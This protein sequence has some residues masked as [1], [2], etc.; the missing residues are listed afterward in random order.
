VVW[1]GTPMYKTLRASVYFQVVLEQQVSV[2]FFVIST[3]CSFW[4]F[5]SFDGETQII[6]LVECFFY[7]GSRLE[8][9]WVINLYYL[10]SSLP[11]GTQ[12]MSY[13]LLT[14]REYD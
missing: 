13:H 3:P 12:H 4:G 11:P 14:I 1:Y 5:L 6:G 7:G 9:D 2:I 10:W 8:L